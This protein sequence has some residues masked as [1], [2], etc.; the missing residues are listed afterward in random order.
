ML[1]G[2][3]KQF[4]PY[5]LDGSKTHTIRAPR[6]NVLSRAKH[7]SPRVGETCHCYTG[8]RQRGPII[9]K[10]A[11][12]TVVRQKIPGT[13]LGRWR[14]VKVETIE[15]VVLPDIFLAQAGPVIRIAGEV[16]SDDEADALAYRDGFRTG[17]FAEMMAFW[18]G[19]LPFVGNIIHWKFEPAAKGSA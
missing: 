14:C 18:E 19:R 12:G 6:K 1:L 4:V 15:I 9:Q 17:G 5:I 8:L 2:F 16:L 13:L 3:K 11:S 10:L 7:G